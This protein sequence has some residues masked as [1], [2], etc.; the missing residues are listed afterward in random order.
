MLALPGMQ[1]RHAAEALPGW[2]KPRGQAVHLSTFCLAENWPGAHTT[3]ESSVAF[4]RLPALHSEQE[5][6]PLL[7]AVRP[8][9]HVLHAQ[10]SGWSAKVSTAHSWHSAWSVP[11][12]A[13]PGMQG[14]QDAELLSGWWKPRGQAVQ[15]VLFSPGLFE[16]VPVEHSRH[17]G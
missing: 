10:S 5:E 1:G 7:A 2:W 8:G 6:L 4:R 11:L 16:N 13:L 14:R 15:A 3:Q 17:W 12:L 9:E